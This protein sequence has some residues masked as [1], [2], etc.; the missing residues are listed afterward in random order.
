L[1]FLEIN[2]RLFTIHCFHYHCGFGTFK[3]CILYFDTVY[4]SITVYCVT[5]TVNLSKVDFVISLPTQG[6]KECWQWWGWE[7]V[8]YQRGGVGVVHSAKSLLTIFFSTSRTMYTC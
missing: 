3:L 4:H 1:Y 6:S 8:G 5:F 7:G 2:L